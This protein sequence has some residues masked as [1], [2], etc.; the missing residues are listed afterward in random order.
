MVQSVDVPELLPVL[1]RGKHRTP[2]AGGCFMEFVSFL[3]GERWSDHPTCTHPL[4]ASL[5][6]LVN[7]AVSDHH[8]PHLAR[9]VPRVVGLS[10]DDV[11]FDAVVARRCGATA[12]PVASIDQQRALAV[13]L[14]TA[15]R[16][17][18][19]TEGRPESDPSPLAAAA[20]DRFPEVTAWARDL[21]AGQ[22]PSERAYRK[23]AAPT[24]VRCAVQGIL[25]ARLPDPDPVL[26]GLL[27]DAVA[28]AEA[29][30]HPAP[31]RL[32]PDRWAQG[33]DLLAASATA[34]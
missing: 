24:A 5:A 27:A 28:D 34:H 29:W 3:A 4:L 8:R 23:H 32:D 11:R 7:D 21:A 12:L 14:L 33:V 1:S 10:D 19:A 16:L 31:T 26:H 22:V 30:V 20:L 6:R 15:D 2:A 18:A 17:L 13:A 9:L 25:A